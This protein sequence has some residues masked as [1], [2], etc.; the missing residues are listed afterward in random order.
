LL[1]APPW[2]INAG[3]LVSVRADCSVI[4]VLRAPVNASVSLM[5]APQ[6]A[7]LVVRSAARVEVSDSATAN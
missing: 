1:E 3:F 4:W 7:E 6:L 5:L 2:N